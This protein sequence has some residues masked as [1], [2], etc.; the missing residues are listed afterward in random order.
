MKNGFCVLFLVSTFY[1]SFS[2]QPIIHKLTTDWTAKV[3]MKNP[4][5]E[6]PRPLLTRKSW[7]S[8]NGPWQSSILPLSNEQTIPATFD[9]VIAVPFAV[10]STLSGVGKTVGKDSV[11]W[12]NRAIDIP[13][14][15][16]KGKLILHFGAV[17]WRAHV[18]VNGVKVTDHEGGYDAF[19][20]DITK[21]LKKGSHQTISISV[22]DPTDDGPQPRGKQTKDPGGIFYT[23]VTGI[24]QTVWLENVPETYIISTKQTPDIDQ[25]K[26][27]IETEIENLQPGDIVTASAWDG[28]KQIALA[29]ADAGTITLAIPDAKLWSPQSP[30]LYDL[31]LTVTRK[32]KTV[33]E[34]GSYFGMRKSSMAKDNKG[35]QRMMLNNEF[36]FQ[37]GPLD[38]GW[39]PDGLY[40]APTDEALKF[41]IEQVKALGFDMIRKHVKVE[42]ARWY[43]YCDK[44][45]IL[46]WQDMPSG[47]MGGN[48]W[49][50]KPGFIS[51]DQLDK[52]RTALSE[53]IYRKELNVMIDQHYNNPSIVTWV[54]FNEGWGQF[55]TKE[56]VDWVLQK[57][58]TRLVNGASGGNY[59]MDNGQ[60]FDLHHYPEPMMPD[61]RIFGDKQIL[62]LG[63]FGGLGL[64]LEGHTWYAKGSWGYQTFKDQESL[65]EKYKEFI[66]G[67]PKLIKLGLSAAIYTQITDVESETNG[68]FTYDRKVLKMPSNKLY[69]LHQ[70]L[71][72]VPVSQ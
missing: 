68:I 43:Y 15:M 52:D 51:G 42:P 39:W 22:W 16:R 26:L 47:D 46:V 40:T 65:F 38:Q 66:D 69:P 56:I 55:K 2:Q 49:D 35:I 11:L 72:S 12:Y 14:A 32:G 50:A 29:N 54:P 61:P 53:V 33:D 36:L 18:Y 41:D 59:L 3:D 5:P 6:Y 20:V 4:L 64:P 13:V 45:G 9:G 70:Q 21:A 28:D 17:D 24:W 44:I 8:L 71:Y 62:V 58:H 60:I 31:K 30:F 63:E 7:M 19:S 57:D 25:H 27:T 37:Y 23:S 48:V 34:V 1:L 10:E 67:I